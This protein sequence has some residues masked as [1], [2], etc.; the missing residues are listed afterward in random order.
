[1]ASRWRPADGPQVMR[2]ATLSG[3]TYLLAAAKPFGYGSSASTGHPLSTSESTCAPCRARPLLARSNTGHFGV[4]RAEAT[5][6][7]KLLDKIGSRLCCH[8]PIAVSRA[9]RAAL[10][11]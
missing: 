1:M 5:T 10:E 9:K 3:E 8:E 7:V 4:A 11:P 6:L 2:W